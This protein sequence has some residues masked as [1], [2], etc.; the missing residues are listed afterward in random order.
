MGSAVVTLERSPP[1]K[2]FDQLTA[3]N[4]VS[5]LTV[6]LFVNANDAPNDP[7]LIVRF[8]TATTV[9]FA[10]YQS[11]DALPVYLRTDSVVRGS[12]AEAFGR[13]GDLHL[14]LTH[15]IG[16]ATT[17]LYVNGDVVDTETLEGGFTNWSVEPL[18]FFKTT[19]STEGWRGN[20]YFA[21]VY[22]RALTLDEIRLHEDLGPM[23]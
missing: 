5:G 10:L 4:N 14:V 13:T 16:T 17:T 15:D 20:I 18:S 9:N 1:Q 21:A 8:G 11:G 23:P 22:S 19:D 12:G 6:E 7:Q 2:L 3:S